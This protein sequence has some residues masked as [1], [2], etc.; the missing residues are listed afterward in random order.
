M[1]ATT[2]DN[3]SVNTINVPF[4]GMILVDLLLCV[5]RLRP[6]KVCVSKITGVL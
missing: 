3:M 5:P 1:F 6:S 4:L 2:F